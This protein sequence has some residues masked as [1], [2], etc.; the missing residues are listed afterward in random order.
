MSEAVALILDFIRQAW[1]ALSTALLAFALL[2]GLAQIL[3]VG[4]AG[5]MGANLW[6]WESLSAVMAVIILALFAFLGIPQIVKALQTTLPNGAGCGPIGSLGTYA[7]GLIGG[8]AT[9]RMLKATFLGMLSASL[10][11]AASF[12]H[13]LMECSEAIFGM[14]LAGLAVPLAAWVLGTC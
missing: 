13:A 4:S 8:L 1:T 12:S 3:R 9:L 5:V 10:G 6:V 11:G 7:A 2:G 14:L